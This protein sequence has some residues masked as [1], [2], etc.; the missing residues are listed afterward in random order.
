MKR[1]FKRMDTT[2]NGVVTT[3]ELGDFLKRMDN[4]LRI[5]PASVNTIIR[6]VDVNGDGKISFSEFE[7]ALF[8]IL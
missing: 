1:V 2:G 7:N 6:K 5:T 3:R 8:G 4:G